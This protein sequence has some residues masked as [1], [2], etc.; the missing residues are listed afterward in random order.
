VPVTT[1]RGST[2]AEQAPERPRCPECGG[3]VSY[4]L[5]CHTYGQ[6]DKFYACMPCDSAIE[7]L[8]VEWLRDEN[9][10][11]CTW[12]YTHGL[13]PANPRSAA[14]E[15]KRPSWLPEGLSVMQP[16]GRTM[17]ATAIPGVPMLGEDDDE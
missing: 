12:R 6:G 13:N 3:R 15:G 14:N 11:T 4:D 17:D 7:Y 8:C 16:H 5:T 2:V 9:P 10:G 1:G